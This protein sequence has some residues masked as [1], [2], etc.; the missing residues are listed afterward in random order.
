VKDNVPNLV[1]ELLKSTGYLVSRQ[2]LKTELNAHPDYPSLN[3]IDD[4]FDV[5]GID[6][7]ITQ[8]AWK[9]AK[10]LKHPFM[11]INE[12]NSE[13]KGFELIKIINRSSFEIIDLLL[14]K[15]ECPKDH[16]DDS[17]LG[18]FIFVEPKYPIV[19][20]LRY[21]LF[22]NSQY[23]FIGL[24]LIVGGLAGI[25]SSISTGIFL[26]LCLAG[27]SVGYMIVQVEEGSSTDFINNLCGSEDDGCNSVL[28]SKQSYVYQYLKLSDLILTYFLTL[29]FFIVINQPFQI[30]PILTYTVVA[31]IPFSIYSIVSQVRLTKWCKLCMIV[32]LVLAVMLAQVLFY[33]NFDSVNLKNVFA[34]II[35]GVVI[36]ISW[37]TYRQYASI[38]FN[39]DRVK[40]DLI[41]FRRSVLFFKG[42]LNTISALEPPQ[43][44]Q[45]FPEIY[46]PN[47]IW[48]LTLIIKPSCPSCRE[49]WNMIMELNNS[50]HCFKIL[51]VFFSIQDTSVQV[52]ETDVALKVMES[53]GYNKN[54]D[55]INI[56][57]EWMSHK[58]TQE[59]NKAD[60]VSL[61][62]DEKKKEFELIYQWCEENKI[63][64]SPAL[65]IDGKPL[66]YLYNS[67]DLKVLFKNL[68]SEVRQEVNEELLV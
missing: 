18:T 44:I 25:F 17:E 42:Y 58:S 53:Y 56:L 63:S 52:L 65:L 67:N 11:V 15:S 31:T 6:H 13:T 12:K 28:H 19:W 35:L 40:H 27:L 7:L 68:T 5:F 23:V 49:M 36:G 24:L 20:D 38:I 62:E 55:W 66:P 37:M 64:K 34:F 33:G 54:Q 46:N 48:H 30:V 41:A 14:N 45:L 16:I 57:N 51:K 32:N 59:W 4:V 1:Y 10:G 43:N 22:S 2:R 50:T 3:A 29:I 9:E 60:K 39:D 21:F 61:Y 8:I 26:I 47:G